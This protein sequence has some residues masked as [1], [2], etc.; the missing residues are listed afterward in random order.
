MVDVFDGGLLRVLLNGAHELPHDIARLEAHIVVI[1]GF[2][3]EYARETDEDWEKEWLRG[4]ELSALIELEDSIGR[5]VAE[6]PVGSLRDVM[7]KLRIWKEL[8]D[9]EEDAYEFSTRDRVVSSVYNDVEQI[10]GKLTANKTQRC[11]TCA[12]LLGGEA[13]AR[14]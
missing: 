12:T 1:R 4:S 9:G 14:P 5:K 8:A 11:P 10:L 3:E 2:L 6:I 13:L 7:I